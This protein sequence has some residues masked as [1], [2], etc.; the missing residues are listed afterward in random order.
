MST[1]NATTVSAVTLKGLSI[2]HYTGNTAI[3]MDSLGRVTLPSQPHSAVRGPE[4][5]TTLTNGANLN[6]N[7]AFT[8]TGNHFNTTNYRFTAPV[9][10]VYLITVSLYATG[11]TGRMSIKINNAAYQNMQTD[12]AGTYAT[13][14]IWKL[15]NGDYVTVGDWQSISGGTVYMGHSH[16]CCY[17]LG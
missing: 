10:G 5:S 9:T 2:Q 4:S 7:N 13:S 17:L 8:N 6:F 11:K 15:N 14:V 16:F 3:V 1:L 12:L